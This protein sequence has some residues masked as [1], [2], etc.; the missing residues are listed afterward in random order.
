MAVPYRTTDDLRDFVAAFEATTL[1]YTRW[2]HGG[3][4]SVAFW[5]LVWYGS[6]TGTDRVRAGI[7]RY[8][9]AHANEPMAVGYH[10][11]LTQFWLW[12][13]G[14]FLRRTPLDAPLG[15]LANRLIAECSDRNL[16]FTYYSRDRLMS[17]EARRGW[18]EP[19]LRPL[20]T[21]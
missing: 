18:V 20:G 9:A 14:Q 11:T 5:C 8:N 1:P 16:P 3:H 12:R 15:E 21:D 6:D 7:K 10:E 19:D 13:V 2:N 17:T 4:L